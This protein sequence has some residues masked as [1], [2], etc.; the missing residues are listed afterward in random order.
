MPKV[1]RKIHFLEGKIPGGKSRISGPRGEFRG[2]GNSRGG[3][4]PGGRE[5]PGG[6][7]K[8][9]GG[10][11]LGSGNVRGGPELEKGGPEMSGGVGIRD[12]GGQNPRISSFWGSEIPTRV[13]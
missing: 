4:I 11:N 8:C 5:I 2:P 6:V 9:P 13:S 12:F 7:R 3:E 10:R 1:H